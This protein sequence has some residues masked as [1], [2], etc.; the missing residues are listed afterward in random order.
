MIPLA[1]AVL[2]LTLSDA[3]DAAVPARPGEPLPVNLGAFGANN[4]NATASNRPADPAYRALIRGLGATQMRYLGGSSASFWDWKTGK[5]IKPDEI[6]R[7]W[8]EEHGNWMLPLVADVD[9]LPEGALG[10][11]AYADFAEAAGVDVQWMTNLTTRADDQPAMIELLHE[12]GV[13][14]KFV[15]LDNE[16]YF[17]GGEFGGGEDRAINYVERIAPLAQTVRKLYPDAEIG[18]VASENGLFTDAMHKDNPAFDVWNE[19][20]TRPKYRDHYDAFILHHYVMN[21]GTLDGVVA[22]GE[23]ADDAALGSRFLTCP[24]LTL[25]RAADA[26]RERHGAIPMWITEYN[27]I[28]YYGIGEQGSGGS[29]ADQWLMKT[30]NAPWNALYQA[31]FWLTAL[32][33]PEAMPVLNHHSID[34]VSLGW[35]LGLPVSESEADLTVT[36]QIFAHLAHLAS[37]ATAVRTLDI[38]G[39]SVTGFDGSQAPAVQGVMLDGPQNWAILI[40]RGPDPVTIELPADAAKQVT[41]LATERVAQTARVQLDGEAAIWEQGP[42]EP[43]ASEPSGKAVTL[44]GFSLSMVELKQ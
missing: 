30:A 39:P 10:P 3:A 12:R 21:A 36:G 19:V 16:T 24:Q 43:T 40:N 5:Y 1:L 37:E 34:N 27:V 44:P 33:H 38:S 2:G 20:I 22:E 26:L 14:V 15:E 18:V 23:S 11:L 25:E 35:G 29:P 42:A 13:P 9:R 41:Y 17:W 7:I 32:Q 8:P 6:T 28:G 4:N 31:G